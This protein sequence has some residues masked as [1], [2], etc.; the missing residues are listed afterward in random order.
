VAPKLDAVN[1]LLLGTAIVSSVLVVGGGGIGIGVAVSH[2]SPTTQASASVPTSAPDVTSAPST[3]PA[4][5]PAPTADTRLSFT[6]EHVGCGNYA[7]V[8]Y[9]YLHT[10]S[11]HTVQATDGRTIDLDQQLASERA[12]ILGEPGE[13]RDGLMQAKARAAGEACDQS[14]D[15]QAAAQAQEQAAQQQ[16]DAQAQASATAEAHFQAVA[17]GS[18]AS[19]G[20]VY[21]P[22]HRWCHGPAGRQTANGTGVDCSTGFVNLTADGTVSQSGLRN[23]KLFYPGCFR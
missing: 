9:Q 20:G 11:P 10:G 23:T 3:L 15:Q 17:P 13:S 14:V 12:T 21:D 2:H 1:R 4:D 6:A 19:I 22:S 5:T 7:S 18:C 8:V 16:R